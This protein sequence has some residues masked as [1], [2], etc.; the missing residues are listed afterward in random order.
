M[1]NR[2]KIADEK[3]I[4]EI[5]RTL[6]EI[7]ERDPSWRMLFA[8]GNFTAEQIIYKME[9]DKTFRGIVVKQ[10]VGLAVELASRGRTTQNALDSGAPPI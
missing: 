5:T 7:A 3:I 9:S 2:K 8:D 6:R 1:A 4:P 10:F